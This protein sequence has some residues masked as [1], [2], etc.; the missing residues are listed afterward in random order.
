MKK[1]KCRYDQKNFFKTQKEQLIHE[2]NCPF[3]A[4][5]TDLKQCKYDP[6]HIFKVIQ[7]EKHEKDCPTRKKLEKEY[8]ESNYCN[9][10]DFIQNDDNQNNNEE[11]NKN[12]LND[13]K[14]IIKIINYNECFGEEDYIFKKA[15]VE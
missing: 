8:E 12:N 15:Y 6:A 11:T 5:R 4:K 7:I 2:Q 9:I 3:K 14:V 13:D 1:F 10:N